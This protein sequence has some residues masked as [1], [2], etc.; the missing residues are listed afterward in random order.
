MITPTAHSN[1]IAIGLWNAKDECS[2]LWY[3][4][5]WDRNV[6]KYSEIEDSYCDVSFIPAYP[7]KKVLATWCDIKSALER[8]EIKH[9]NKGEYCYI[10][11]ASMC[12]ISV[13]TIVTK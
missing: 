5:C 11:T 4:E 6:R 12:D 1:S 2:K 13:G 7:Y 10:S 9:D 3:M 8:Q